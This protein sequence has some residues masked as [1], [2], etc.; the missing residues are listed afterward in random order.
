M[1]D[2]RPGRF[3]KLEALTAVRGDRTLDA[4]QRLVLVM[5]ISHAD[6]QGQCYPAMTTL[7]AETG[8]SRRSVVA[9]LA[10]LRQRG[11]A[12]PVSVTVTAKGTAPK[13]GGRPPN[14]YSLRVENGAARAPNSGPSNAQYAHQTDAQDGEEF[15]ANADGVMR[16]NRHEFSAPVALEAGHEAVQEA[17]HYSARQSA[18]A[19]QPSLPVIGES[20]K[21]AK[22][23]AKT[24]RKPRKPKGKGKPERTA[25]DRADYQRI[26]EAY[27]RAFERKTGRKP[28]AF[29][30][31]E[32]K[33]VWTLLDKVGVKTAIRTVNNAVLSDFGSTTSVNVI[34]AEPDRFAELRVRGGKFTPQPSDGYDAGSDENP[35]W[36]QKP[37]PDPLGLARGAE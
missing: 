29:G 33:S 5:L 10:D 19:S 13:G 15:C 6:A 1:A 3:S 2:D 20:P 28:A 31:R 21:S 25:E 17:G 27:F 32:G 34:A 23:A 7:A 35:D 24:K 18:R 30:A 9:A 22:V 26:V 11:A 37:E 4:K 14:L 36:V 16:K 12:T 8:L